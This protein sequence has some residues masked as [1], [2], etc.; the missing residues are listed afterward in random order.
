MDVPDPAREKDRRPVSTKADAFKCEPPA[1]A[2]CPSML[3]S[4]K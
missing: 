1:A 3:G 4:V 2:E